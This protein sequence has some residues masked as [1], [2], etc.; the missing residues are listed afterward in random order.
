[1]PFNAKS[2]LLGRLAYDA[3]ILKNLKKKT[4]NNNN[5][6]FQVPKASNI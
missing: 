6:C 5:N 4:K 1:L 3:K 2:L